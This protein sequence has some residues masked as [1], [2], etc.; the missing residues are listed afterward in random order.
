MSNYTKSTNFAVKDTLSSG[1]PDKVVSGAEIDNEFSAI[2][3]SSTSK[4]DK[5]PG[6]QTGN[7]LEASSIG[8]IQDTGRPTEALIP[9]GGI[10]LWSGIISSIPT[11]WV[12]CDGS[13]GTPDLRNRFIVGA[14]G[15]YNRDDTGGSDEVTLTNGQMPSH[16][17]TMSW[18]GGHS[19]SGNTNPNGAHTHDI[20]AKR[21]SSSTTTGHIKYAQGS[22][23]NDITT[24]AAGSHTHSLNISNVSNHTHTNS[25]EGND[26]A[27]ENRPPYYA[28]AYIM[29]L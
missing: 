8:G 28:L 20:S 11:G 22:N 7:V 19:H 3:S 4:V 18:E 29:K 5:I 17:H 9:A 27:H 1:D 23:R 14:G 16:T 2:S 25:T 26:Q 21:D 12:L 15:Q 10:I 13:N 24:K 6:G